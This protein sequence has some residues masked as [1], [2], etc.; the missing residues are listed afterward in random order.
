MSKYRKS[1]SRGRKTIGRKTTES[2]YQTVKL[3]DGQL[4]DGHNTKGLGNE[5]MHVKYDYYLFLLP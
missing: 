2:N 3:P 5:V 1:N 4:P